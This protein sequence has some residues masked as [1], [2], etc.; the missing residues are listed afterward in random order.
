MP[1]PHS[2]PTPVPLPSHFRPTS[3]PIPPKSPPR[4]KSYYSNLSPEAA[5]ERR[6][7]LT[8]PS[9]LCPAN[10]SHISE[11][12]LEPLNLLC[13]HLTLFQIRQDS[14]L[15]LDPSGGALLLFR[16]NP[17]VSHGS[18]WNKAR[19]PSDFHAR[20][21]TIPHHT[22]KLLLQGSS[23]LHGHEWWM[24]KKMQRVTCPQK[25]SS[26]RCDATRYDGAVVLAT[27]ALGIGGRRW[28]M[29]RQADR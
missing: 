18:R 1:L 14:L 6:W 27:K 20:I 7:L 11:S 28:S 24:S 3:A 5:R 19:C 12:C 15:H 13:N 26:C 22:T 10:I 9:Q 2:R 16:R 25:R 23:L 29:R 21:L 8:I 4:V 17:A